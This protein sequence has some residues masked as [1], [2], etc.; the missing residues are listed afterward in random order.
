[1]WEDL[2]EQRGSEHIFQ[3]AQEAPPSGDRARKRMIP[4]GVHT[5]PGPQ[6][7]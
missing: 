1:M 4:L 6:A 5:V 3:P 7:R 2:A